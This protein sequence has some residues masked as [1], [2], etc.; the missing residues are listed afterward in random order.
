MTAAA[1]LPAPVSADYFDGRAA[2]RHPVRLGLRA[3]HLVVEGDGVQREAPWA[4]LRVSEPMG[5]AARLVHFADGAYCEVRDLAGLA[6]LLAAAGHRDAAHV[7][8]Q[9]S[10]RAVLV[11]LAALV[12]LAW[13]MFRFGLPAAAVSVAE[14]LPDALVAALSQPTEDLLDQQMLK[15]SRLPPLR[16]QA[17][18]ARLAA[19]TA[20]P[21]GAAPPA[22]RLQFRDGGPLGANA[23][24]LPHGTVFL[25]D[26]LVALAASDD[27]VVAVLAHETGHVARRHGMRL[28][29]QNA[30]VA[31]LAAWYL[32]DVSSAAAMLATVLVQARYSRGM[33]QE[34]DDYAA[35]WL[36]VNGRSPLLL[37][38]MLQRLQH[39]HDAKRGGPSPAPAGGGEAPDWFSSHPATQERIERLRRGSIR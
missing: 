19:L 3:G 10:A 4:E 33:E 26:Q 9:F 20:R 24:A 17:I 8:W 36:E 6:A 1:H 35:A 15:P 29:V 30:V 37:A 13:G 11:A 32:G 18:A 39:Q 2:R 27:E 12:A 25:T 28:L 21:P 34:A 31:T 14:A 5:G 23:L 16:Q 38:D 22:I 7:R